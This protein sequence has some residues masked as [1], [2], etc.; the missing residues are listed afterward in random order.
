MEFSPVT[1]LPRI[2]EIKSR[3]LFTYDQ[4]E[5]T[6]SIHEKPPERKLA[7]F[8]KHAPVGLRVV[9]YLLIPVGRSQEFYSNAIII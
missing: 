8:V 5:E 9:P 3:T 1:P 4:K 7:G 6:Q 2:T